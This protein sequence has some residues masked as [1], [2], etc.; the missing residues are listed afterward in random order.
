MDMWKRI[1]VLCGSFLVWGLACGHLL[2]L[3]CQPAAPGQLSGFPPWEALMRRDANTIEPS[4]WPKPEPRPDRNTTLPEPTPPDTMPPL[5]QGFSFPDAVAVEFT[6]GFT[7]EPRPEP[8]VEKP[9]QNQPPPACRGLAKQPRDKTWGFQHQ[10]VWRQFAVHTP[11]NYDPARRTPVVLNFHG[12]TSNGWQQNL[13]SKMKAKS[14]KE[15]FIVVHPQGI[16]LPT[17]W[18]AGTCCPGSTTLGV[19]DVGFVRK[20]LDEL[21][22]RLCV[23]RRRIYAT[24]MSNGGFLSHRLACEL[25]TRLAAIAPVAG[26]LVYKKCNPARPVPVIAFH[27]T[28]DSIVPIGGSKISGA[29]AFKDSIGFWVKRNGCNPKPTTFYKK[30]DTTCEQFKGCRQGADVIGCIS[31]GAGHTWPGGTPIPAGKTSTS[32]SATDQMWLF[33]QRHRLP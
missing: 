19:D 33:F 4:S 20:M 5:D 7:P 21:E 26:S 32:I 22:K 30:G 28:K 11:P 10:L 6:Q 2:S 31:Q 18:N 8:S 9:D 14:D 12:L 13:L 29:I 3:G 23:D 25:S 1:K 27:G 24:G 17:S 16:G 15:G